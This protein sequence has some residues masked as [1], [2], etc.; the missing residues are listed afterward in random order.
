MSNRARVLEAGEEEEV[1]I[2]I[3]SNVFAGFDSFALNHTQFDDWWRID[4][5][6][7]TVG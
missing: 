7:V 1:G 5:S 3:E 2:V 4:R 6:T